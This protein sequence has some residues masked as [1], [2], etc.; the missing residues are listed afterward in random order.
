[1][2]QKGIETE[3]LFFL[4]DDAGIEES[5]DTPA[6]ATETAPIAKSEEA[7]EPMAQSNITE[8]AKPESVVVPAVAKEPE[9]AGKSLNFKYPLDNTTRILTWN[10]TSAQPAS[11]NGTGESV[12]VTKA[13]EAEGTTAV[14]E[15]QGSNENQQ[16]AAKGVKRKR[17]VVR[18]RA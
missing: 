1:M 11:T 16:S 9:T 7:P 5:G 13:T 17:F 6:P 3:V 10:I 15:K 2:I 8:E 4:K 14:E 18:K 12:S